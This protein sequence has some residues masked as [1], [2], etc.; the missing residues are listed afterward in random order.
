MEK[1]FLSELTSQT[2]TDWLLLFWPGKA[3]AFSLDG[4]EKK[5]DIP[6][7][8]LLGCLQTICSNSI[9]GSC[10]LLFPYVYIYSIT[11]KCF[12]LLVCLSDSDENGN[13]PVAQASSSSP[14]SSSGSE[15]DSEDDS[16]SD[17]PAAQKKKK[18]DAK[19]KPKVVFFLSYFGP[20]S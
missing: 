7:F 1:I 18:S 6:K 3:Q 13:G 5:K 20:G 11:S 16:D 10:V 2:K 15:S 19:S 9:H 12:A 14:E 4:K 8:A 17:P